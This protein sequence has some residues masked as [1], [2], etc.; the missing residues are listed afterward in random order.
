MVEKKVDDEWKKKAEDE[1]ARLEAEERARAARE[2]EVLPA[3]FDAL[4]A[5]LALQASMALGE[6]K[7]PLT[8]EKK[9]DLPAARYAIDTLAVLDEKTKGNLDHREELAL[10]NTLTELRFKYVRAKE[11]KA[12]GEGAVLTP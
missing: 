1:R 10:K 11:A 7:H 9:V 6:M 8:G 4:V 2:E 5:S 12:K 3:S